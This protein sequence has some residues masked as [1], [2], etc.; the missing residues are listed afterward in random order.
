MVKI[1]PNCGKELKNNV[2]F[3]VNCGYD[4]KNRTRQPRIPIDK[5]SLIIIVLICLIIISGCYLAILL[6]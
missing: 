6:I 2:K 1:C 5:K 4:I 3:C